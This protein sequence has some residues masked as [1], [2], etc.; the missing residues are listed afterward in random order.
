MS[1]KSATVFL[2]VV[3][4]N[5]HQNRSTLHSALLS[6]GSQ[7][8]HNSTAV[9]NTLISGT[10]ITVSFK[11]KLKLLLKG[12]ISISLGEEGLIGQLKHCT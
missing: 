2:C 11:Q 10:I 4:F 9:H 3:F 6:W 12:V 7:K 8:T 1:N 5:Y